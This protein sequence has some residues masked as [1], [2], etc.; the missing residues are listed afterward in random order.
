MRY[1]GRDEDQITWSD[2]ATE[3]QLGA[4]ADRRLAA[5]HTDDAF[6]GLVMMGLWT[7][8]GCKFYGASSQ[9]AEASW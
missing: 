4:P 9:C 5:D 7:H 3:R 8:A 2:G 6:N 1:S